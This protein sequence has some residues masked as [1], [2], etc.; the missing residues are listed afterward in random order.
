M[1][2]SAGG[3]PYPF[4]YKISMSSEKLNILILHRLGNPKSGSPLF[5]QHLLFM[6][7]EHEKNH[8]YLYHDAALDLPEYIQQTP[9]HAILL[10]VTFLCARWWPAHFSEIRKEYEFVKHSEAVKIAFPNDESRGSEVLDEWMVDWG[11]DVVFSVI[12]DHSK[13]IYPKYSAFGDVRHAY[14]GYIYDQLLN[15]EV[16]SIHHHHYES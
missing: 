3:N 6:L 11:V 12:H 10:D 5:I 16:I 7:K 13:T 2:A 14:A 8:N 9:F 4:H 15:V 1:L